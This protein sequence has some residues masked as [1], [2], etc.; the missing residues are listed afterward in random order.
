[1]SHLH[2][3]PPSSLPLLASHLAPHLPVSLP[4]YNTVLLP[5][6]TVTFHATF[7]PNASTPEVWVLLADFGNQVRPFC[8]VESGDEDGGKQEEGEKLL[9]SALGEWFRALPAER[10][11]PISI[12]AVHERW[13]PVMR[14]RLNP[15]HVGEYRTHLAPE[16]KA[17]REARRLPEGVSVGEARP[18]DID[19]ILSTSEVAH[20]PSYLLS[21]LPFSTALFLATPSSS[22]SPSA[23]EPLLIA[24]CFTHRDGCLGTLHVSSSHR[25][26]GLARIIIEARE[27]RLQE[28]GGEG[29]RGFAHVA[30]RNEESRG[31]MRAMG[32]EEN[33][34]VAWVR[35]ERSVW[36]GV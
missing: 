34:G 25:R 13:I 28:Q 33:W 16:G 2:H 15:T 32:W 8:S 36:L 20:P 18:E 5:N 19:E 9:L 35:C 12:G 30:L 17:E 22:S 27:K 23:E 31:L 14:R 10:D 21:R 1:M 4:S 6:P 7:P 29:V 24:S 3:W 11:G 26:Q